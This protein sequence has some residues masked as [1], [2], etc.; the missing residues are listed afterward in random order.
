MTKH[1]PGP[2]G[3]SG[4]V[5]NQGLVVSAPGRRARQ[6]VALV[7]AEIGYQADPA[8][9]AEANARLIALAPDLLAACRGVLEFLDNGTPIHPGSL[10]EEELQALV[11]KAE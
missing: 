10:L 8:P 4:E 5:L 2:W 11:A 3:V 1:T 6:I 9:E 7:Q